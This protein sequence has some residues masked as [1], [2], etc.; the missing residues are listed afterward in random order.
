MQG[1]LASQLNEYVADGRMKEVS[2]VVVQRKES[3]TSATHPTSSHHSQNTIITV[4]EF[5]IN[6]VQGKPVVILLKMTL[7]KVRLGG[8]GR[9]CCT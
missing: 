3:E 7:V 1:M 6:H 8:N 4:N 9:L 5:I 2:R